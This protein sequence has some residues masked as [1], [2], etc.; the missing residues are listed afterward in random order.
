MG[1]RRRRDEYTHIKM[2]IFLAFSPR[3]KC[4]R[5]SHLQHQRLQMYNCTDE[6]KA[7]LQIFFFFRAR[8]V[9][10]KTPRLDM[11]FFINGTNKFYTHQLHIYYMYSTIINSYKAKKPSLQAITG[12]VF[13]APRRPPQPHPTGPP[14]KRILHS[15]P[16][17]KRSNERKERS[18]ILK[19]TQKRKENGSSLSSR[20]KPVGRAKSEWS[21]LRFP[22]FF[23]FFSPK[24][25]QAA[26][27]VPQTLLTR[28]KAT[29]YSYIKMLFVL[30]YFSTQEMMIIQYKKDTVL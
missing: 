3:K 12:E 1:R 2:H 6:I 4:K 23:F 16:P 8:P 20:S 7:T 30:N 27:G 28:E 24:H 29:I 19:Q 15:I 9:Q 10:K 26:V 13:R 21:E 18:C 11:L 5:Q 22:A 17:P 25:L 14:T